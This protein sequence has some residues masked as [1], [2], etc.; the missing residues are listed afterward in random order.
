MGKNLLLWLVRVTH[1]SLV[2]FVLFAWALPYSSLKIFHLFFVP[3]VILHWKT[4]NDQCIMT[5]WEMRLQGRT[6]KVEGEFIKSLLR[7]VRIELSREKLI[8]LVYGLMIA[9]WLGSLVAV[10]S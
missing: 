10:L 1:L 2:V 5:Q 8:L 7:L 9:S 3:L 6:E 4:N